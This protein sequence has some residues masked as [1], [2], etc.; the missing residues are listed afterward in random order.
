MSTSGERRLVADVAGPW[1]DAA[2]R[3]G[4]RRR[5]PMTQAKVGSR[6]QGADPRA[7][8]ERGARSPQPRPRSPASLPFRQR[9]SSGTSSGDATLGR[10]NEGVDGSTLES[11]RSRARSDG[12]GLPATDPEGLH[13]APA[14]TREYHPLAQGRPGRRSRASQEIRSEVSGRGIPAL[15]DRGR[16]D[17]GRWRRQVNI[18][19]RTVGADRASQ[20]ALVEPVASCRRERALAPEPAPRKRSAAE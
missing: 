7:P 12:P 9:R 6:G 15:P 1:V 8:R 3:N 20:V 16:G 11:T 13:R 19:S 18:V 17:R 2:S 5:T 10:G 14:L 4:G